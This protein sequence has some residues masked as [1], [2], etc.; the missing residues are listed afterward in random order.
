MKKGMKALLAFTMAG[1]V[2][3]AMFAGCSSSNNGTDIGGSA[4]QTQAGSPL[5]GSLNLTGSTSMADVSN[6]LA[7]KFREKNPDVKISVGG[8]GSGEA[9]TA[10]DGGTAQI[11]LLSREMKDSENPDHYDIYKIGLDGIAIIVNPEN[12]VSE[13]TVEQI[14]RIYTGEITNWK[15]LGGADL[16]IVPGGR[17]AASGTRSAFEEIIKTGGEDV[18]DR[19]KYANEYNS[20]GA[21]KQAVASNP[22]A[23]GYVSLSSV[24]ETVKALTIEGVAPSEETVKDGSYKIQRPFIMITQKA[25]DDALIRAFLEF[26]ASAEGQQVILDDGVVPSP[27]TVK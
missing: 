14:G 24:D 18:K 22:G 21:L 6:A 15:E 26:V 20:T 9:P 25:T 4:A 11:G 5:S 17:E 7:E 23:I 12:G 2:L 13:L 27:I 19:C 1:A 16:P 10:V 3:T 8:N